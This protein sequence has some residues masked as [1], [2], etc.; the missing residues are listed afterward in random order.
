MRDPMVLGK[1]R[2][3]AVILFGMAVFLG[4]C[5]EIDKLISQAETPTEVEASPVGT[6]VTPVSQT[7][8]SVTPP[9]DSTQELV[10]WIPP[11]F[12]PQADTLAAQLFQQQL[13]SFIEDHPE[14][15]ITVRVKASSGPGGLL[16]SLSNASA[17]APDVLPSLIAL[18]RSDMEIAAVK[19]LIFPWN[20]ISN[21]LKDND[22]Y[23]YAVQMGT[24]QGN[25]YGLPFFGDALV[26]VYRPLQ[27]SYAPDN[28][29]DYVARGFP[30][31]IPA[32]DPHALT[33]TQ[34]L[35]SMKG[36]SDSAPEAQPLDE[37]D[38][39]EVYM[40]INDAVKNGVFPYWM[41]DFE[42]FGQTWKSFNDQQSN[43][44]VVWA[45]SAIGNL[46]DNSEIAN[47]PVLGQEP[48]TLSDGWMWCI[49]DP[50]LE[51][52]KLAAALA[53][54]LVNPDFLAAW[55]EANHSLPTRRSSLLSWQDQSQ[56][57]FL[58]N[59]ALSAQ[60]IPSNEFISTLSPLL[61]QSTV[62]MVRGQINYLQALDM[63]IKEVK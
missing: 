9:A 38:L 51:R 4:G 20:G 23:P 44:A 48:Y 26:V 3:L 15:E 36:T 34:M 37:N 22:W 39:K 25:D 1:L 17:A 21:T 35:Y 56:V 29:N 33:T 6:Q 45:S 18:P 43:Y 2:G 16:D 59:V 61:E 32:A 47:M 24:L 53:E 54:H 31:A 10:L 30:I 12:D 5:Q 40:L 49:T 58:E 62:G 14:V 60:L 28:W 27:V 7:Q 52:H 50:S 42:T 57:E 19:G 8:V 46:P 63:T 11:Q 13:D 41:G 55:T